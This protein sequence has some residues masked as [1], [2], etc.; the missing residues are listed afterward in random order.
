MHLKG[1]NL[2]TLNSYAWNDLYINVTSDLI[3]YVE[4]EEEMAFVLANEMAH[5]L[6]EHVTENLPLVTTSFNF[7]TDLP[8]LA[9]CGFCVLNTSKTLNYSETVQSQNALLAEITDNFY[10]EEQEKEAD[11]IAAYLIV[12]SGYD[13]EKSL[14]FLRKLI[15]LNPKS[16]HKLKT[17]AQYF[18]THSLFPGRLDYFTLYRKEINEKT[19]KNLPLI[20]T[21]DSQ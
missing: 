11:Y 9:L 10:S 21:Q 16:G 18:D 14:N 20:P 2:P 5:L 17:Q 19:E 12:R 8:M 4:N 3:S 7:K 13:L 6:A 15:V 1:H